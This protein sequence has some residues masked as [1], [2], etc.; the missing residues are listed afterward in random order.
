MLTFETFPGRDLPPEDT[1]D[2]VNVQN[3]E[4]ILFPRRRTRLSKATGSLE[5]SSILEASASNIQSLKDPE[6]VKLQNKKANIVSGSGIW[7]RAKT[8]FFKR[9]LEENV[10]DSVANE[11]AAQH[12]VSMSSSTCEPLV[13]IE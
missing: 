11:L 7:P 10:A 2:G 9:I 4:G 12:S 8:N 13:S 1:F 5:A 6:A 3:D